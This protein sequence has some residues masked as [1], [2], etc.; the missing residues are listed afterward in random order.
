MPKINHRLFSAKMGENMQIYK[1]FVRGC[2]MASIIFGLVNSANAENCTL[3]TD[4]SRCSHASGIEDVYAQNC[5]G[6]TTRQ[7][8][9]GSS[10]SCYIR[11][12]C[13][14]CISGYTL[15]NSPMPDGT[16]WLCNNIA[17][18]YNT[19]NCVCDESSKP[20]GDGVWESI[21]NGRERMVTYTCEC[22]SG[23][24]TWISTEHFRCAEGYWGNA[25]ASGG[26]T[27]CP[28]IGDAA[29]VRPGRP[30]IAVPGTSYVGAISIVQCYQ[31]TTYTYETDSGQ[32]EL[33]QDCYYS[34]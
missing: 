17:K 24:P 32:Y 16:V 5:S 15:Q 7:I 10:G 31:P 1:I 2:F 19:C 26:C 34:N 33:T 30:G 18:T 3:I 23:T 6:G 22:S 11:N 13:N 14:R 4:E 8:Y 9:L 20:T 29:I 12:N 27:Q 25:T 28:T 21:S